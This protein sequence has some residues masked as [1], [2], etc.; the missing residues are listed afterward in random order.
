[1]GR[2]RLA[3]RRLPSLALTVLASLLAAALAPMV[4]LAHPLGNFTINHYAGIRVEPALITLDVVIDMAE[5]PTFQERIRLDADADGEVSDAEAAAARE[6]ECGTLS[7]SLDLRIGGSVRPLDLAAAGLSF[8][9][10][11]GGLPT[12]RLVCQFEAGLDAPIASPTVVE[13]ADGSYAERIGWREIVAVGS[14]VTLEVDG[15]AVPSESVSG[16]LTNYPQDRLAAP[17]AARSVALLAAAGGPALAPFVAPDAVAVTGRTGAAPGGATL[18]PRPTAAPAAAVPGGVGAEIPD[19]FR[20]Q[21]LT[22]AAALV[23]LLVAAALG[24]GHAL[25]P[26]HGKTL[27]AAYLVG[28]L[29][30]SAHALGL[31]LSVSVAHTLGILALAGLVVGAERVLAP[32]VLVGAAQ[33]VAAVATVAIG[34]WMLVSELRR[35]WTARPDRPPLDREHDQ[36]PAAVEHS[37]G[38]ARHRHGPAPDSPEG[39][40][41]ATPAGSTIT[42]RSLFALGLA[43][44]IIPSTNALLILLLSIAAGRAAFGFVLVAAFGLGMAAVMS[45]IGLVM[46]HARALLDRL[47]LASS[48]RV[49]RVAPLAASVVV[50]ALGVWLTTHVVLGGTV[51]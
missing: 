33:L 40:V 9:I 3:C 4:A 15:Q 16:R 50:L 1:M 51:L 43:G 7:A 47:P 39:A 25:T 44:G 11:S 17:L 38:G 24:A 6:A 18:D 19:I 37:H 49:A 29:G 5:I 14:G 13:F 27:M 21:D 22:P 41:G 34:A 42:W 36:G 8:P 2:P 35:R 10:G 48:G 23:S 31:G 28:T 46:V 12:L 26:G 30:R 45:A 32:D 20:D